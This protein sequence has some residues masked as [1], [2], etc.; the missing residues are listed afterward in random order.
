MKPALHIATAT[1]LALC[2]TQAG[3]QLRP[4][5][6]S[7]ARD[8][9]AAA[10]YQAD[11]I[12]LDSEAQQQRESRPVPENLSLR[13]AALIGGSVLAMT[14]YGMAKWW[15][16]GFTGKFRAANEGW[17][18]QNTHAGGADKLGHAFFAYTGTRLLTGGFE[19]IGNEPRRALTFGFW[20]TLGIMTAIE[21]ADGY[22]K[23]YRFSPQDAIMNVIGAGI[24]YLMERNP[25]LDRLVDLRLHY[26]SSA[27]SNFDPG[28][29]Y[30]GQTYLLVLKAS[31]VPALRS[32]EPLRYLELVLGYGS[33]G[34]E[35]PAS[36][37]RR[38]VYF[39]VSLNISEILR[40]T[41]FRNDRQRSVVQKGSEMFFEYIQV[42]GTGIAAK[43]RL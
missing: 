34:Y 8:L 21:V 11:S 17:F 31:G 14:A 41:A 43:H 28:G 4:P 10:P 1:L 30:S 36:D 39:G 38:N 37:H 9:F 22:S 25:D 24:G 33:R 27:H 2:S 19:L 20:T 16:D 32:H 12:A 42:P 40:Q 7:A 15:D 18:G 29:D 35:S 6:L 26:R 23:Q 3:A 13:N 5:H